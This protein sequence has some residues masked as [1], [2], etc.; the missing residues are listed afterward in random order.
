MKIKVTSI[1]V[2]DQNK[3]LDFYTKTLGFVKK[4]DVSAGK[5]PMVNSR[6]L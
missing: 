4:T 6:L 1:F 2:N 3:A 5:I